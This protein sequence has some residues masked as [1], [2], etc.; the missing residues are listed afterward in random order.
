VV[1]E[2]QRHFGINSKDIQK[3]QRRYT[4]ARYVL[5]YLLRRH[6]LMTLREIGEKVRLH[7]SAVGNVIRQMRERP[8]ASQVKSLKELES[9]FK[10]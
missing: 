7:Y 5:C 9:R 4:D 1:T 3:R 8:T 2:V 10:I 6:C